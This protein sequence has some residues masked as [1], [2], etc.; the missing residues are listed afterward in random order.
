M[1]GTCI[2]LNG[3][4]NTNIVIIAGKIDIC[5]ATKFLLRG[6]HS[7]CLLSITSYPSKCTYHGI[8]DEC[9]DNQ[10]KENDLT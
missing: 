10:I 8:F 7:Q 9:T 5:S 4:L 2:I 1:K 6:H 3:L